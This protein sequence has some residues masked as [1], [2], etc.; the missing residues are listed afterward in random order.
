MI[1]RE[2]VLKAARPGRSRRR[3]GALAAAPAGAHAAAAQD[4]GWL[5]RK[6]QNPGPPLTTEVTGVR[7][8]DWLARVGS[9]RETVSRITDAVLEEARTWQAR[10]LDPV[11]AVVFLDA[12]MVNPR[13]PGRPGRMTVLKKIDG[14]RGFGHLPAAHR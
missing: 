7:L 13:Q 11:W 9:Y 14:F 1:R 12:I 4:A 8:T 6:A 3:L 5:A 2:R 10:P